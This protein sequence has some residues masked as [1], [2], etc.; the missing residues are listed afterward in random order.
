MQEILIFWP[1][2]EGHTKAIP[3]KSCPGASNRVEFFDK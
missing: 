2:H 1:A 3:G